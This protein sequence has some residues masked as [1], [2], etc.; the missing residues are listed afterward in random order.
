VNVGLIG[1]KC[2]VYIVELHVKLEP[3]W[4]KSVEM[5]ATSAEHSLF[6]SHFFTPRIVDQKTR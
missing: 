3:Q 5:R 2:V 4:I 6:Y 1:G